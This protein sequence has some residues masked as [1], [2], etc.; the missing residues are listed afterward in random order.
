MHKHPISIKENFR[1]SLA[2]RWP[3]KRPSTGSHGGLA[4]IQSVWPALF[5]K[6]IQPRRM[7]V[8]RGAN[9]T[10]P[11]IHD[12]QEMAHV[13]AGRPP[14][15][16]YQVSG[17]L[18]RCRSI[19]GATSIVKGQEAVT[20]EP[21]LTSDNRIEGL[22]TIVPLQGAPSPPRSADAETVITSISSCDCFVY[23]EPPIRV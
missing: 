3:R 9:I 1:D 5:V 19:A 12:G 17:A 18:H 7:T 20:A 2:S 15:C 11:S 16:Q 22:S 10:V 14:V 23:V 13:R 6:V 8:E 4:D 21:R